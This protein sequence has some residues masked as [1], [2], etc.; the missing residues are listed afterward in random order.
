MSL[1]D[2][3]FSDKDRFMAISEIILP[4][5][6]PIELDYL[7]IPYEYID[8]TEDNYLNRVLDI[9]YRILPED[10]N[11]WQYGIGDI[12]NR[13]EKANPDIKKDDRLIELRRR[14]NDR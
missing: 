13:I 11:C 1:I 10:A 2:L 7:P 8:I 14:W 9:L 3:A 12:F 5:L 4:L 6:S